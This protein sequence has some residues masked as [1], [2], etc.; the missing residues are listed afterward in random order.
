[1]QIILYS[2]H[3]ILSHEWLST[4]GVIDMSGVG[5]TNIPF[6]NFSISDTSDFVKVLFRSLELHSDFTGVIATMLQWHLSNMDVI[7]IT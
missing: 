1:M 6:L 7:F 4:L 5:V 3:S 2:F